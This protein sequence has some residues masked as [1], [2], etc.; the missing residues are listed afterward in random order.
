M[1]NKEQHDLVM[2]SGRYGDQQYHDANSQ[3]KHVVANLP[4]LARLFEAIESMIDEDMNTG[5]AF[6][7]QLRIE[8]VRYFLKGKVFRNPPIFAYWGQ[9]TKRM[10]EHLI[11]QITN[12]VNR[13]IREARACHK[14]KMQD[15][16]GGPDIDA[17]EI[18]P[19]WPTSRKDI[20][21][22]KPFFID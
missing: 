20:D 10:E 2:N 16:E 1:Y 15:M 13:A 5:S 18:Q 4:Y 8:D 3:L 19:G 22:N 7:K 9:F 17:G 11:R 14:Y 12:M 6:V 21:D